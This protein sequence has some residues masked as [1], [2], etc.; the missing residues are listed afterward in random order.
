VS[1]LA[2]A[3]GR[4]QDGA[5][6]VGPAR[7]SRGLDGA[8]AVLVVAQAAVLFLLERGGFFYEDDFLNL[9]LAQLHNLSL[10]YLMTP[11]FQHIEPGV[12]L[13]Y[14]ILVHL[15]GLHYWAA[16]LIM[17]SL[18]GLTGWLLY[19]TFRLLFAPSMWMV[20]L[21][22]MY[23]LWAGWLGAST[24]LAA[25]FEVVPSALASVLV[26]Y[27]FARRLNGGGDV[28]IGA[29]A[30]F[31]AAGLAFYESTMVVIPVLVLCALAVA[32]ERAPHT[33]WR[34]T[35]RRA[36]AP[37]FW[38]LFAA[39]AFIAVF[40]SK[41]RA[42]LSHPAS[43]GAL[44]AFLWNSWSRTFV[45]SLLGGPLSWQ[46][47]GARGDGVAPLWLV[48]L[49]QVLLVGALALT[50]RRTGG[51]AA[52]GWSLVAVPFVLLLTLVGL[53]RITQFGN[54]IG[55]DYQYLVDAFVPAVLGLGFVAM[56]RRQPRGAAPR[57]VGGKRAVGGLVALAYLGAFFYS[58]LP[59]AARWATNPAPQY[60]ARLQ[61]GV[62]LAARADPRHWSL[63]NTTVPTSILFESAWPY[64]SLESF[65]RL[66][67]I[68]APL[69]VAG[70]RL[71]V[72]AADGRVVLG[73]LPP[74]DSVGPVCAL[75]GSRVDIRLRQPLAGGVWT[76]RA[77]FPHERGAHVTLAV[78]SGGPGTLSADLVE[79]RTSPEDGAVLLSF[80]WPGTIRTIALSVVGANDPCLGGAEIG[81]P[82]PRVGS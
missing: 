73:A 38:C 69:D 60:L 18:I 16:S 61:V 24:W 28:W 81:I 78:S 27:C 49:A 8:V 32:A 15:V 54:A 41:V 55:Q 4:P 52:I 23:G 12:R 36:L 63:Y 65:T 19:R 57:W 33:D 17:V 13:E 31:F 43:L 25:A 51:R 40:L 35:L 70:S 26:L 62:R 22:G 30:A 74:S 68:K 79:G 47:T 75:S 58:S 7:N 9:R 20:A 29:T 67:G 82:S 45:P 10:N 66:W 59:A 71:F 1:A 80:Y 48:V 42:P 76:I 37:L 44:L 3:A 6:T 64:T 56:G 39:A 77:T 50:V 72:V 14:W 34:Q 21:V 2:A 5:G 46:W 11:N 53:A